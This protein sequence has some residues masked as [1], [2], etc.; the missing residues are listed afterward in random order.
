MLKQKTLQT[1]IWK[2]LE[3]EKSFL[4]IGDHSSLVELNP[5]QGKGHGR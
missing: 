4:I 3:K 2:T 1:R 5:T